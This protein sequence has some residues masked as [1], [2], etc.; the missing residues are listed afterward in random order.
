M[1]RQMRRCVRAS[2]NSRAVVPRRQIG[3]GGVRPGA[4][5]TT[6]WERTLPRESAAASDG[7]AQASRPMMSQQRG[8]A[9]ILC[10]PR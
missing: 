5:A 7:V 9:G 4:G 2:S 1:Q 6:A 10:L 3:F 8:M